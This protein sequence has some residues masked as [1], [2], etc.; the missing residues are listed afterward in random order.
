MNEERWRTILLH[1]WRR[2]NAGAACFTMWL[3]CD[4]HSALM[5]IALLRDGCAAALRVCLAF[6]CAAPRIRGQ[7]LQCASRS[8]RAILQFFASLYA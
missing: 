2:P 4:N 6:R 8:S 7:A 3:L 5:E 1:S